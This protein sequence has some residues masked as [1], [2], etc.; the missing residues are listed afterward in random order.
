MTLELYLHT[1]LWAPVL[2]LFPG[3]LDLLLAQCAIAGLARP[4]E[5]IFIIILN[6]YG[7]WLD[8][9]EANW[10]SVMWNRMFQSEKWCGSLPYKFFDGI[11]DILWYCLQVVFQYV[12]GFLF[13][14]VPVA[15]PSLLCLFLYDERGHISRCSLLKHACIKISKPRL[16]TFVFIYIKDP[17]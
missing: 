14:T 4:A 11:L 10:W 7:H 12:R 17:A 9:I 15:C 13:L 1:I 6:A 16:W 3:K 8:A 2:A 5:N